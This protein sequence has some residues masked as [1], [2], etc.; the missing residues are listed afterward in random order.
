MARRMG[1]PHL[2]LWALLSTV[3]PIWRPGSAE[4]RLELTEEAVRLA[5]ELGEGVALSTA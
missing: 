2:L 5:T 1:E 3:L 4:Q